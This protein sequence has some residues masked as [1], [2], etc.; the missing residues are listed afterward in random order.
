M[1]SAVLAA[2]LLFLA[3]APKEKAPEPAAP[4][5][6]PP[7]PT[8]ADYAGTWNATTSMTGTEKPVEAQLVINADGTG[9]LIATGRDPVPV[10]LSVAGDSL[11]AVSAEYESLI[12]KG[13]KVVARF[14]I[15]RGG[16]ELHGNVVATYK[17]SKGD[18]VVNGT[19]TA[20]KAP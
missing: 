10:T 6:P 16:D 9:N 5:P 14:A 13:V 15:H 1:R 7:A 12:R 11:I 4:P 20:K 8:V 2:S 19:L 18:E 3:C 17:T